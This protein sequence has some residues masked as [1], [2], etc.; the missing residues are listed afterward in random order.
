MRNTIKNHKDFAFPENGPSV[1]TPL[2]IARARKTMWPGDARYGLI[3]TKR[4]MKLAVERNR[5]KRL[6]RTWLRGN[7]EIM[8]LDMD[9]I[10]ILRRAILDADFVS[11]MEIVKKSLKCL[12]KKL[13][14]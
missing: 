6:I 9:Y 13:G 10:F 12:D 7:N 14:E 8:R 3:V 11:G 2:F 4:T 5:A 1:V